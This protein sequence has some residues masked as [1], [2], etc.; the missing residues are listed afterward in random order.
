MSPS[1]RHI[2]FLGKYSEAVIYQYR[3]NEGMVIYRYTKKNLWVDTLARKFIDAKPMKMYLN[4][5]HTNSVFSCTIK[6]V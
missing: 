3:N 1:F 5:R 6:S 2:D 4:S